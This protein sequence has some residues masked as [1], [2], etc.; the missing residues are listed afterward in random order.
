VIA[1]FATYAD[2]QRAV[3]YLADQ[4]FSVYHL[5]IVA[6]GLQFVEQVTGRLT[7]GNVLLNGAASGATIGFFIGFFVGL[8][9]VVMPFAAAFVLAFYGI[10]IGAVMGIIL[11]SV[12]YALSGHARDFTSVGTI[13][14]DRYD[15]LADERVADEAMRL[16]SRQQTA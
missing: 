5:S 12:S 9:Y 7:W 4:K 13:Q 2:A 11:G 15:V 16:L 10:V 3:D 8:L 6:H 1:S 14:A